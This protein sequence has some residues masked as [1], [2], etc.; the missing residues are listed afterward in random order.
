MSGD[1]RDRTAVA[2]PPAA[3]LRPVK[4]SAIALERAAGVA[5]AC[6]ALIAG[7]SEHML[8]NEA[9]LL[10][11]RNPEF[12][13][14][15]RV[16][17]RR[18]RSA[19]RIF[20]PLIAADHHAAL[21]AE[22]QW[23]AGVL[24]AAR[25]WD[26]FITETLRPLQRRERS[27]GL[28]ALQRRCFTQRRRCVQAAREALASP[29][30]DA[31]KRA[32]APMR[33]T[34]AWADDDDA[35]QRLAMPLEAFAALQLGKREKSVQRL[36]GILEQ[37]DAAQRHRLRIAAKKLRYTVEFFRPLFERKAARRYA[38][39]LA[40]IQDALGRMNDCATARRLLETVPGGRNAGADAAAR[41][42][43]R[44]WILLREDEGRLALETGC[45]DWRQQPAFW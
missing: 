36:A 3:R 17:L 19:F 21:A 20:R 22:M 30:Y 6:T 34:P 40:G 7:C 31:F 35:R 28:A 8:A 44:E 38:S 10:A 13:H 41:A 15:F 32:L 2:T 39:A 12:L 5:G 11:R 1:E 16:G 43:L 29:R 4:A 24:G 18:L 26:V 23:L 45:R 14:Q 25:D 27:A 33:T 37:A 42:M 9:G